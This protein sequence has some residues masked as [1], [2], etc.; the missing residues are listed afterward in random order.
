VVGN[1]LVVDVQ[2]QQPA[3]RCSERRTQ[4]KHRPGSGAGQKVGESKR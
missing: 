4:S 1:F 3:L 2:F